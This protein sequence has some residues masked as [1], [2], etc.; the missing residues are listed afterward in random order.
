[1]TAPLTRAEFEAVADVSR[2]TSDRLAGYL[3]LLAKWNRRINLVGASTLQDPWR[4]HI[5][6]SIQLTRYLPAPAGTFVDFG[7]GAGLPGV[8]LAI[9]ASTW[10]ATLIE[11]DARKAAFLQEAKRKLGLKTTVLNSRIESVDPC[12]ADVATARA[13]APVADLVRYARRHLTP[14]GHCLFL[15]GRNA[16]RELTESVRTMI[17][18]LDSFASTTDPSASVLR[19]RLRRGEEAELYRG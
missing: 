13:L 12:G 2:E 17:V 8:P 15:K 14:N 5:L 11:S 4:R 6:D 16:D 9:V 19:F 3:D 1:V 10:T 18:S 7:S